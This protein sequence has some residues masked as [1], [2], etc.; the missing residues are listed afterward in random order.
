MSLFKDYTLQTSFKK[1]LLAVVCGVG[2][3]AAIIAGHYLFGTFNSF[4]GE[5]FA[6][7]ALR[8]G[9]GIFLIAF[10]IWGAG[11]LVIGG[12]AWLL[13]HFTGY[14]T[15]LVALLLGFCLP[16]TAVFLVNTEFLTGYNQGWSSYSQGGQQWLDGRL[17]GFGW[18][19]AAFDSAIMGALGIP[20]AL[21]VWY[22]SYGG[23]QGLVADE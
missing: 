17:T 1:V 22:N 6:K 10:L 13:L 2:F 11:L 5:Y 21:L 14:R 8:N 9:A 19:M 20:I 7:Y 16:F 3:G 12:P 18:W 23:K 4:G 15:W